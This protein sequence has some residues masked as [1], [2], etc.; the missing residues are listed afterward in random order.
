MKYLLLTLLLPLAINICKAQTKPVY[1]Y[2]SKE[3]AES[4]DWYNNAKFGMFI[5]IGAYTLYE[6]QPAWYRLRKAQRNKLKGEERDKWEEEFRDN[7]KNFSPDNFN[8][9]AI[10]QLAKETGMKW[11][12]IGA[13]HHEGFAVYPSEYGGFSTT[14][15]VFKRDVLKELKEECEKEGIKLG[16]YYSHFQDWDY[17]ENKLFPYGFTLFDP[18]DTKEKREAFNDYC[19]SKAYPQVK[20]LMERYDPFIM[21]YDT[22][23]SIPMENVLEFRKIVKDRNKSTLVCNRVGLLQGDYESFPDGAVSDIPLALPWE[24]C[25]IS[26]GG[27][28]YKPQAEDPKA[29]KSSTELIK[30]LC[31]IASNGGVFLLNMGLRADGGIPGYYNV[32][33]KEVGQWVKRNSEAIYNTKA[34][35]LSHVLDPGVYCTTGKNKL[36][37]F[38]PAKDKFEADGIYKITGEKIKKPGHNEEKWTIPNVIDLSAVNNTLKKAYIL[39][40]GK[41]IEIQYKGGKSFIEVPRATDSI[42]DVLV[43]EAKGTIDVTNDLLPAPDSVGEITILP[44]NMFV[45]IPEGKMK[46]FNSIKLAKND[47]NYFISSY[48][49][50]GKTFASFIAKEEGVYNLEIELKAPQT[51]IEDL[52]IRINDKYGNI[53]NIKISDKDETHEIKGYNLKEGVNSLVM[54]SGVPDRDVTKYFLVKSIKLVKGN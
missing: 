23:G 22:P 4:L 42:C 47:T 49:Y 5:H 3:T 54:V 18:V 53:Q 17:K 41:E 24:T 50:S 43:I 40:T 29:G 39:G 2:N 28:A 11:I 36:Y 1:K 44:Q 13:K 30:N 31:K 19:E 8:A 33:W 45:T 37:F 25:M 7:A 32:V 38:I 14:E 34:N 51:E 21:W 35:P 46:K 16:F 20:E 15:G 48:S 10:V 9:K 12:T 52:M 27:W 6:G 26:A